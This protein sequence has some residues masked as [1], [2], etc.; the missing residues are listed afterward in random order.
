FATN[1]GQTLSTHTLILHWDGK[2][3]KAIPHPN[4]GKGFDVLTGLTAIS[5]S[6][7]WAIGLFSN[8]NNRIE[9]GEEL[10]E[11]W[12]GSSWTVTKTCNRR[13]PSAN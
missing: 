6:D 8:E 7:V 5:T 3:W 1:P 11:H 12:N 2:A 9:I 4:P 10:F 13:Q